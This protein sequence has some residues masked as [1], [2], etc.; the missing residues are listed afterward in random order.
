MTDSKDL[1]IS[2]AEEARLAALAKYNI[3]NTLPEQEYDDLARLAAEICGTPLAMLTFVEEKHQWYKASVGIPQMRIDREVSFCTHAIAQPSLLVV[4]D[5]ACDPRFAE[6]PFVA[7][8]PHVRFYAGM[9]LRTADGHALGTICVVDFVPRELTPAQTHALEALSRQAMCLL[10]LHLAVERMERNLVERVRVQVDLRESEARLRESE[11]KLQIACRAGQTGLW[12]DDL[13]TRGITWSDSQAELFGLQPGDFDGTLETVFSRVHPDDQKRLTAARAFAIQTRTPLN[14]EIRV[15]HGDGKVRWLL[16]KGEVSADAQGV[17]TRLT[18]ST[19]DITDRKLSEEALHLSE[20]YLRRAVME[21]PLILFS[22][23]AAGKFTL[24]EGKGLERL[25]LHPG[26]VVGQ[27]VY[28]LYQDHPELLA[29]VKRAYRGEAF[30][31]RAQV[32]EATFEI[33]YSPGFGE[34]G[35][36]SAVIGVA[37]DITGKREAEAALRSSE[38]RFQAFMDNIPTFAYVKDEQGR[39]VYC[40]DAFECLC[41]V[42]Q[43]GCLGRTALDFWPGEV[44]RKAH[45]DSLDTA[46][47]EC[48]TETVS[49]IPL[50]DGGVQHLQ[51]FRFTFRDSAGLLFIGCLALD[52]T[53]QKRAETRSKDAQ[54]EL[55]VTL[56]QLNAT[57]ESTADGLLVVDT[58]GQILCANGN[59]YDMWRLTE[60]MREN[61]DDA[62]QLKAIVDKLCDPAAFLSRVRELYSQPGETSFDVINLKDGRI[63]ERYSR[64]LR[65][66]ENYAGRVWSFRDITEQDQIRQELIRSKNHALASAQAKSEF[67]ANMS[68]EIRT[69][70]N[71]ILGMTDLLL[72]T[73]LVPQ[74]KHYA[75]T[76]KNSADSLLTVIN[77]ILDFSKIEA[78]KM[79]LE[80]MP[81]SIAQVIQEV[82]DLLEPRAAEKKLALVS[83]LPPNF[84]LFVSGDPARLRQIL[85][86]LVGNA[87]KFTERGTVTLE[88]CVLRET[89]T[90]I[91]F[92]LSVRDTGIGIPKDRQAAIFDSFTQADGSITRRYGGTGLGLAICLRLTDLMAGRIGLESKPGQGSEFWVVVTLEKTNAEQEAPVTLP[93]TSGTERLG[94]HVLLAEDNVI[95]QEVARGFLEMWGCTVEVAGN[96][97]AACQAAQV[98]KYDLV[99]MDIQMPGMDGRQATAAIRS[100]ERGTARRLPI[101][102]MT[103]HNMHGDREQCLA[104]GMDDYVSKPVDPEELL[105]ALKRWGRPAPAGAAVAEGLLAQVSEAPP[106]SEA[107]PASEKLPVLDIERLHRSCAGKAALE[108]RIMMEM[109]RVTPAIVARLRAAVC[110]ADA[111]QTRFEAHTLKGSSRTVGAEALGMA[112]SVLEGAAKAEHLADAAMLLDQLEAEWDAL[113]G[114]LEDSLTR[115]PWKEA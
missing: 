83:F 11:A 93:W 94:L 35:R 62:K 75:A 16:T 100:R 9:P 90:H 36:V 105:A 23:D 60:E 58:Q 96:G 71:G 37:C 89:S 2:A 53:E 79:T 87:V 29:H 13:R 25:G 101:V 19:T 22:L 61:R 24:F 14:L 31:D 30:S 55:E 52:V 81:F 67:L 74:Q 106:I 110:A 4:P 115:T 33:W 95:N 39:Y 65:I 46:M 104:C 111:E 12:D 59:F 28:D 86:N 72:S 48:L 49:D 44:G 57:L 1:Q 17:P 113:F 20:E 6:N 82:K 56:S 78:G 80:V 107:P 15:L 91:E 5:T 27:S 92:R 40:N 7:G 68:H 112:A 32:R 69:P 42:P 108:R 85:T 77:D 98:K 18:G 21:A 76:I 70:M 102:A 109:L 64:P 3:L 103:A 45:A 88:G 66:Q 26:Q 99:L 114:V 50:V 8:D 34:D 51:A 63:L 47:R 38:A 54:Q 73:A 10:E 84:P 41:G 97:W 43:G